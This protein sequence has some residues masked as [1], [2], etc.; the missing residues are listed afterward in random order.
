MHVFMEDPNREQ[1]KKRFFEFA[2]AI[3]ERV[4]GIAAQKGSTYRRAQAVTRR[5]FQS[6][7]GDVTKVTDENIS[8]ALDDVDDP[9]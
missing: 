1:E 7:G 9:R 2:E 5:L 3:E 6:S 4:G 8:K